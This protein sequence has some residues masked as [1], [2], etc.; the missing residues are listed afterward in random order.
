[1]PDS[2]D[3]ALN[4]H[5]IL[6]VLN[7]PGMRSLLAKMLKLGP[8]ISSFNLENEMSKAELIARLSELRAVGLVQGVTQGYQ[9]IVLVV[10]SSENCGNASF[11]SLGLYK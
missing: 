11:V 7:E 9:G 5:L 2:G 3:A 8:C 6:S 1:M 10:I 4:K